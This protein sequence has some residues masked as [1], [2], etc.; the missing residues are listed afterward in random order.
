MEDYAH[1]G[2]EEYETVRRELLG[3]LIGVVCLVIKTI[4][5]E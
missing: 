4:N 2:E 3:C 1:A 5:E